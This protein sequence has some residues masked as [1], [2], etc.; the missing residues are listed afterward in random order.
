MGNKMTDMEKENLKLWNKLEK[1]NP[2]HTKKVPSDYGKMI[3]TID[4][5][6]QI[7]NMTAAFGP[8]GKGWTYEAKK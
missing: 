7:K 1:T 2:D 8:I 6:H 3:T 4:A 5:M